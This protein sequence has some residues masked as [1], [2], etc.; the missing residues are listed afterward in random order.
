MHTA[1]IYHVPLGSAARSVIGWVVV[2]V[3]YAGV[4]H[5]R[6]DVKLLWIYERHHYSVMPSQHRDHFFV[7]IT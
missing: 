1:W 4:R 5:I 3:Q 2:S 6:T 7:E